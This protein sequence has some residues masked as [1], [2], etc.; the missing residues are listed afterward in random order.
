[1]ACVSGSTIGCLKQRCVS[2]VLVIISRSLTVPILVL[3]AQ[4]RDSGTL[5]IL[6][7]CSALFSVGVDVCLGRWA[8]R[9]FALDASPV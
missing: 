7:W 9:S 4:T 2:L 5:A 3:L 1:M 6:F 8:T